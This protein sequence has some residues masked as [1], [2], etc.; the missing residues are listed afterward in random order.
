MKAEILKIA[1]VK[2]EKEFYKKFPDEKSFMAKHGGAFKKAKLGKAI[3]PKAQTGIGSYTGGETVYNPQPLSFQKA[4]DAYDLQ[5]TGS[6]N[7]QRLA[8]AQAQ[9]KAKQDAQAAQKPASG[10]GMDI[11]KIAGM[12]GGEGGMDASA[13]AGMAKKGKKIP[14][15][16]N[17]GLGLNSPAAG[18]MTGMQAAQTNPYMYGTLPPLDASGQTPILN[19][20]QNPPVLDPTYA[21]TLQQQ[22]AGSGNLAKKDPLDA[23]ANSKFAGLSGKIYGGIKKIKAEKEARK[24]AEQQAS[25]SDL[26]LKAAMSQPE[27]QKRTYRRPEDALIQPEQLFPSY[28][29]GTNVLTARDGMQIGGNQ[30]EIQNMY[31]PGDLYQDLGY[32]PLSDSEIVKQYRAGGLIHRM[33]T[34]G[35]MPALDFGNSG[36]GIPAPS[37]ETVGNAGQMIGQGATGNNAGGEVGADIGGATGEALGTAVAGPAGKAIG[38]AI[39]Q[40]YGAV[41]GGVLDRNPQKM[42]KAQNR[43][44]RNVQKAAMYSMGQGLQSQYSAHVR[45]GGDIPYAEDGWVSNDWLPQVITQFGEHKVSDLLKPDPIMDT[46]RTGGNISQNN[47]YPQ[48]RYALGGELK[49]T[50]GGHAET[51]SHNPY[52]PGTGETIMFRG[53][54]HEEGDGNGHTGIGVKYGEGGKMTDYAEFGSK[55]ADAD[56]EVERGEPAT[57]MIDGQTGEKNMVVFG[58]LKIPNQFLDQIGDPKAKGKKFKHYI[59]GIS[60]D[61]A[62]QNKIIEK[63]SKQIDELDVY[64]PFDKLKLEGLNATN[65]GAN[66]KLQKFAEIKKN[67]SAVQ[68]AINETAKEHGVDADALAKGKIKIDKEAMKQKAKYGKELFKAQ[69]GTNTIK[70]LQDALGLDPSTPG[71]GKKVGP[72]T[73]KAYKEFIYNYFK[74]DPNYANISKED[75]W[76]QDNSYD[77]TITNRFFKDGKVNLNEGEADA[78]GLTKEGYKKTSQDTPVASTTTTNTTKTTSTNRYKI[79]GVQPGSIDYNPIGEA[80]NDELWGNKENYKKNWI[81]KVEEALSDPKRAKEIIA[82]LEA[83][84][85]QDAKDVIAAIKAQK[86]RAGKIAKIQELGTDSKIGP[87]HNLLNQTIEITKPPVPTTSRPPLKTITPPDTGTPPAK[88]STTT[89]PVPP[90]KRNSWMDV[91]NELFPYLRPSDVD[92]NVDLYPEMMAAAMNQEEPVFVQGYQP[93]LLTPY[94]ISYQDQLNE[95]TAQARAAERMA[96]QNPAAAAALL[97][98]ASG[99][100]NKVLGEQFR[101]NQAQRMG[102]YNQNI[103]T[104]NDAKLKNLA[105]YADQ[106]A[107]QSQARSN[108]KAQAM[109][110]IKSMSDKIAKNKLENKTLQTYENLYNYRFGKDGR[111]QNYNPLAQFDVSVGGSGTGKS[112]SGL[113]SLGDDWEWD[114]TPRPKKKKKDEDNAR[115]GSIVRALKN[116]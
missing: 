97:A 104:L 43:I 6:T 39:G 64:T 45:N 100:K 71:Y 24:S 67:A 44:K 21:G 30:T 69:D 47:I 12:L 65:M 14:K 82:Q 83:Y 13:L 112:S 114:T 61:E 66:M 20:N 49:T 34:G 98:T 73:L 1:G 89:T 101:Q 77:K 70:N 19:P 7:A 84:G 105:I 107:K 54:S 109:E 99:E 51:M 42:E 11:S 80:G 116:F 52:L 113:P 68:D 115:N 40:T 41:V 59:A 81:P 2:N 86:T 96:G 60:K 28:G 95:I 5:M 26:S 93:Q 22:L 4:Y 18:T 10:G 3:A 102:V 94:D 48:D 9:A 103:A 92:Y 56:V 58:N 33:Q 53:K 78:L 46:L 72:K 74:K 62:R 27:Q 110:I 35:G 55:N 8:Q 37:W 88:T 108:T 29:V 79:K 38:K 76:D 87:Y 50:W 23:I 31:N 111:A 17:S 16:Q 91:A 32:E 75:F 36:S 90:I 106:A 57:E 85:G 63:T 15:Y 25:V